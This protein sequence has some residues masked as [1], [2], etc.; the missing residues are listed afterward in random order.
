MTWAGTAGIA[1]H[2]VEGANA[3]RE[4]QLRGSASGCRRLLTYV[5]IDPAAPGSVDAKGDWWRP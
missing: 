4:R 1:L 2:R 5:V 3:H